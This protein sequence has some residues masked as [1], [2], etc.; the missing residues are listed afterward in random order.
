MGILRRRLVVLG[1]V[2][3]WMAFALPCLAATL[4]GSLRSVNAE[5]RR[6]VVVD[7]DGDDNHFLVAREAKIT[8]NGNRASLA[9]LQ[10][11]DQVA[12]TFSE[13]AGGKAT[14]TAIE[15]TRKKA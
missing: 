5:Q 11:G 15:A 4:R 8:L 2:A 13:D 10:P 3:T 7:R 6:V 14:A 9:D 12:V 1:M